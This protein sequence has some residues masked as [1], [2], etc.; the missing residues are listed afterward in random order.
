MKYY[1]YQHS[2]KQANKQANKQA[3]KQTNKMSANIIAFRDIF[4]NLPTSIK[5]LVKAFTGDADVK[6]TYTDDSYIYT[7]ERCMKT[8]IDCSR[9]AI[10]LIELYGHAIFIDPVYLFC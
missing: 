5:N 10:R 8:Y 2:I 9:G 4:R 1:I 7:T 3:T 6:I